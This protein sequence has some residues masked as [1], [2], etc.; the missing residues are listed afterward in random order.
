MTG[1]HGWPRPLD[2]ATYGAVALAITA[3]SLNGIVPGSV[4]LTATAV[5][6]LAA[7]AVLS[8]LRR[9]S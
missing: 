1:S 2:L 3:V 4:S 7:R 8:R 9:R 6:L 5:V